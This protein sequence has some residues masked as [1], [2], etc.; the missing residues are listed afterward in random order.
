MKLSQLLNWAKDKTKFSTLDDYSIFSEQYLSFIYDNLQAVIV[1]QNE[2][3]NRF[4]Q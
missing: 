2:N 4:V 1:S 3:L